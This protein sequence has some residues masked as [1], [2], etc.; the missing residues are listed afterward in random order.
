MLVAG[1][2]SID[3][4]SLVSPYPARNSKH[5]M[6]GFA[7]LAGGSAATAAVALARLGRTVRYVGRFGDDDFGAAG[8]R[9][10]A[11]EGVDT[12]HVVIVPGASSRFAIILVDKAHIG[13]S[14]DARERNLGSAR[15]PAS[16]LLVIPALA[17][18]DYLIEIEAVAAKA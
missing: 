4:V 8:V 11:S 13:P 15:R 17:S 12:A 16:T 2:N 6:E 7:Q 14:R 9:S 1:G 18:P 5:R 10:L 3:L